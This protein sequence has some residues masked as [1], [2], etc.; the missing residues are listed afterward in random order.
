MTD[1]DNTKSQTKAYYGD[2][3]LVYRK[4]RWLVH[5]NKI[6]LEDFGKN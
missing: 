4:Y 2:I 5:P 3:E 1:T 6:F